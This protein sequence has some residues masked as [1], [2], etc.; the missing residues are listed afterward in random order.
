MFERP[1]WAEVNLAA[2][3]HN[4]RQIKQCIKPTTK[5]CAVI[6]ADA[7]GHGTSAVI[8]AAL[9]AGVDYLGVAILNEAIDLR[10][11]GVTGP[12][13]VL[14]YTPPQQAIRIVDNDVTQTIFDYQLAEAISQAAQAVGRKA[15]VHIKI[16]T[17]MTRIGIEPE[18]AGDFAAAVAKLPGIEIEGVFSHFANADSQD[19]SYAW[20][21]FARFKKALALIEDKGLKI[22]IR[23][24]ANSAATLD[25]PETQLDM[26][27]PGIIMYGLWPSDEVEKKLDLKPAMKFKAKVSCVKE[28]PPDVSISYGRD[29]YTDKPSKIATLPVGYADGW[30]RQLSGKASVLIRGQRALIVGRVCMD[31]CMVDVTHIPGVAQGDIA[32]LFGGAKLPAE[33]IAEKLGTIN[34]EVICLVGKRVPRHYVME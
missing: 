17:G 21:Q 12:I 23:H 9:V 20:E 16:D 2:I 3:A 13:L 15:K 5:I 14:G 34:Y 27:R 30:T 33:E 24:I 4:I 22:P 18:D 1:V 25:M 11:D 8:R 31:Q 7:Y 19:K 32:L 29:Y 28:V 6:K 26:V 10:R